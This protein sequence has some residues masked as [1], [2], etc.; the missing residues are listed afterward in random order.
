M[1]AV[2]SRDQL[3][4]SRRGG[5]A[6]IRRSSRD[7]GRARA[8]EFD[9]IAAAAGL[10]PGGRAARS[11][12]G[13]TTAPEPASSRTTLDGC[14]HA[15]L[16]ARGGRRRAGPGFADH[17]A[18]RVV[19]AADHAVLLRCRDRRLHRRRRGAVARPVRLMAW[20][21]P[22]EGPSRVHSSPRKSRAVPSALDR[23][24]ASSRGRHRQDGAFSQR[25]TDR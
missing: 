7:C 24:N 6:W 16:F 11:G 20:Q 15:V 22:D 2:L 25:A 1:F 9:R 21:E 10:R 18:I 13:W 8:P 4:G 12:W 23:G 14:G 19:L 5:G 17:P 3:E